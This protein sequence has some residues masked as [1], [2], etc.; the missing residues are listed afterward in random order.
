MAFIAE[1]KEAVFLDD[2]A[3][4]DISS[5]TYCIYDDESS[6][7][8][9]SFIKYDFVDS[10]VMYENM[11][12]TRISLD[13]SGQIKTALDAMIASRAKNTITLP[14]LVKSITEKDGAGAVTKYTERY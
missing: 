12:L 8:V 4:A 3:S 6:Y 2:S 13:L 7:P 5:I 11:E 14:A 9:K 10:L 1:I